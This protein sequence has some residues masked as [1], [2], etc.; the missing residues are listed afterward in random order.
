MA[1]TSLR[2]FTQGSFFIGHSLFEASFLLF[3]QPAKAIYRNPLTG[4]MIHTL[5]TFI[6]SSPR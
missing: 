3:F 2:L 4:Q 1:I 6:T 5:N